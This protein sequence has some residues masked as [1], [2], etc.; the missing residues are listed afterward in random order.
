MKFDKYQISRL[1][2][3]V[4]GEIAD[5]GKH[6]WGGQYDEDI[7]DLE[8]ILTILANEYSRLVYS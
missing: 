1:V 3:L 7:A 6:N 2:D 4:Q 8:G 5:I